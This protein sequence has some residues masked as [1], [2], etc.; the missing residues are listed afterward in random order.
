MARSAITPDRT[1]P[2]HAHDPDGVGA[3]AGEGPHEHDLGLRHDVDVILGRRRLL[4]LLGGLT[5]AGALAACGQGSSGSASSSASTSAPASAAAPSSSAPAS[6]SASAADLVE[7]PDETAGPFPGDGSNGPNVLDDAGIVRSD[8]RSSYEISTTTAQ[9]VPLTIRMSVRDAATGNAL[10][11]AAVYLWHADRE[12]NYSLYS[13]A[14]AAENYLRGVQETDASGAVEF[15]SVYPG[16]YDGRWPHIHFE[17]YS[18]LADG[19]LVRSDREDVAD[20]AAEGDVRRGVRRGRLRDE[21]AQPR[22]DEPQH[23]QRLPR[24][25]GHPPARDDER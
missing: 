10:A 20:R 16:C 5:A 17:V 19:R 8:I 4:G 21:R 12:G 18:S 25:R 11:G 3:S 1:H 23:R 9:G 22:V 15:V 6:S 7:V 24:R 14:A 2:H 13:D